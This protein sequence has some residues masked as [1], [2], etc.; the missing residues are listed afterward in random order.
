MQPTQNVPQ[1]LHSRKLKA[2]EALLRYPNLTQAAEAAGVDRVTLYRWAKEPAF[3]NLMAEAHAKA[4]SE[5]FAI[6]QVAAEPAAAFL[7]STMR[8]P[9]APALT[10]IRAAEAVLDHGLS[11]SRRSTEKR[12]AALDQSLRTSPVPEVIQ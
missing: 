8:D 6:L 11:S 10:R 5:A 9:A 4:Q 12:L 1:P 2:L 7:L 3:Q